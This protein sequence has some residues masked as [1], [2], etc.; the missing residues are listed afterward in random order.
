MLT[1]L[2]LDVFIIIIECFDDNYGYRRLDKWMDRTALCLAVPNL[3]QHLRHYDCMKSCFVPLAIQ[4]HNQ[5]Y[6]LKRRSIVSFLQKNSSK[7]SMSEVSWLSIFFCK[8]HDKVVCCLQYK[9]EDWHLRNMRQRVKDE[10]WKTH[11]KFGVYL[12][13]NIILEFGV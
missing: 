4:I 10:G 8:Y 3:G 7:L 12:I 2:N 1:A 9:D 13:D 5:H 6:Q 11:H